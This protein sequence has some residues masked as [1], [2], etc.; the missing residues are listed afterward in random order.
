MTGGRFRS[1]LQRVRDR[2]RSPA[3]DD[4]QAD[5][6]GG[7]L[8][9]VVVAIK[10][11]QAA[12]LPEVVGR[13][14]D[15]PGIDVEVVLAPY[16]PSSTL[17]DV[18][19][20]A[21]A[22]DPR[23]RQ[24]AGEASAAEAWEAAVAAT[25]T[26]YVVLTAG[27]GLPRA[28]GYAALVASLE[29]SG[30]GL[31]VG[32][33]VGRRGVRYPATTGPR[34]GSAVQVADVPRLL[35]DDALE[36][37]VVRTT[38][39]RAASPFLDG[40]LDPELQTAALELLC[41]DAPID[42]VDRV[43]Y[44][45]H[46]R[47]IGA[48]IGTQPR[49]AR[50]AARWSAAVDRVAASAPAPLRAQLCAA[51]LAVG[52]PRLLEDVENA[53]EEGWDALV[54]AVARWSEALAE[55]QRA[56][57]PVESRAKAWLVAHDRRSDLEAFVASRWYDRGQIP[58]TVVDGEVLAILELPEDLPD[59]VRRLS[60]EEIV[61]RSVVRRC[62]WD[63]D[64]RLLVHLWAWIPYVATER[65][66]PRLDA[67]LEAPD[68]DTVLLPV[69]PYDD[70]GVTRLAAQR[71]Q[72]HDRGAFQLT[73]DPSTLGEA[74]GRYTL[75]IRMEIGG[76]VRED[77][78]RDT[79]AAG[80]AA[81]IRA[82]RLDERWV[83]VPR[84]PAG[85]PWA[86]ELWRP[87]AQAAACRVVGRAVTVEVTGRPLERLLA[88]VD[89]TEVSAPVVDGRA[90]LE[91][92]PQP[93]PEGA[94]APLTWTVRGADRSGRSVPLAFA[95][96]GPTG[97]SEGADVAAVSTDAG[98]LGLQ[99]V[100]GR[101]C[102]T[103]V[104]VGAGALAVRGRW[105]AT[106]P[107]DAAFS[108]ESDTT[109][110][111]PRTQAAEGDEVVA[112]FD[113]TS[114]PDGARAVPSGAYRLVVRASGTTSVALASDALLARTPW[115]EVD[116]Q[117]RVE[118]RKGAA[119]TASVVLGPPLDDATDS[120]YGQERLRRRY[121]DE[122]TEV[123]PDVFYLQSYDGSVATD[124][125]LAVHE[126]LTRR[127]AP[128]ARYW[129]VPD[130]AASVP[131]GG[132]PLV[133]R[134]EAWHRVLATAGHLVLNVDLDREF[135]KR[136]EQHFLQTFHGYP[137]KAMGLGLWR[138]K[139]YTPRR[140]AAELARTMRDWDLILTPTPEMNRYYRESYGY[141]GPIFDQGL[142][143]DDALVG[144]SAA[145]RREEVRRSLGIE[146][147]QTAVLYAPTWRDD[148]ATGYESAPAVTHLDPASAAR[149][150]GEDFVLLLRGHRFH[151]PVAGAAGAQVIDVSDH[152]QVNDLI[153]AADVGVFDY[154][155]IRFDFALTGRPMLFLVPDLEE[156]TA[157]GRGFLFPFEESAPG[158]LL[159]SADE[160]VAALH[161]L[162]GVRKAYAEEY[163]AFNRRFNDRADGRAAE[164]LVD[165]LLDAS[166][167]SGGGEAR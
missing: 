126:E 87:A 114:G 147:G 136:P 135:R 28:G 81:R 161:D 115:V 16:G 159:G 60:P 154:S 140:V 64:G 55:T 160:V 97:W 121:E 124:T 132:V 163:D 17:H 21:A 144:P 7:P 83:R 96:E 125:P 63:E 158:P 152:P 58:T 9:T 139:H 84:T 29:K 127:G 156:Y 120:P 20:R 85:S 122:A 31:A 99:E 13:A 102:V 90:T 46:G 79:Y 75:R 112:T 73:I 51:V 130:L 113:R 155:S 10:E 151:V 52:L 4:A 128:Q 65:D 108:L 117:H 116:S 68:G 153:L 110:L 78:V 15:Q 95:P 143:R 149:E 50:H 88:S 118:L 104:E 34:E 92:P 69:T 61:L 36:N 133:R 134:S 59:D 165:L 71:Y 49:Y 41:G 82:R 42:L 111:R 5:G 123:D 24:V 93:Q 53:D 137:S 76:V 100:G 11:T 103:D 43:V 145:L 94:V 150:L 44:E 91:L 166:G 32:R 35:H 72:N 39:W 167:Q 106:A 23:V 56:A 157:G 89:G 8:L 148:V 26:P 12:F 109:V 164:R 86:V 77:H 2:L 119:R 138:A 22:E 80:S 18:A 70:P 40:A 54:A 62:A 105:L 37:K 45:R 6:A 67:W 3:T 47:E 14:L 98:N 57:L 162:D 107:E 48:P 27:G 19:A 33:L 66:V 101:F 30:A 25:S 129:G 131:E 142:P 141:E 146:G 74:K 1:R 38:A